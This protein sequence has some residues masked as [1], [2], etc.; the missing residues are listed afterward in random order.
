MPLHP[1]RIAA[2]LL[3]VAGGV[4]TSVVALAIVIARSL[5]DGGAPSSAAD[6]VLLADLAAVLPLIVSFAI[7]N[8]V[9]GV[10]LL[11]GSSS[12]ESLSGSTAVAA[13][14]GGAIGLLLVAVGRDPFAP[15]GTGGPAIDGIAILASWTAVYVFVL[16]ALAVAR[17]PRTSI[18]GAAA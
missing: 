18:V 3:L 4:V 8:V 15:A 5:V 6:A 10:G 16:I 12:A 13:V 17:P 9:A 1:A 14:M 11:A 7:V 2:A